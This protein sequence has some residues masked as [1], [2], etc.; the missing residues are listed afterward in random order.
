ME[1]CPTAWKGQFQGREK[2]AGL[3]LEAVVDTNLWFWHAAFGFS[4]TL[5]DI[6]IWERSALLES[7]VNGEYE[8]IDFNY[9]VDGEVFSIL[10][11]LV[12]G[13][14]PS[15]S[16]FILSESDPHT[17]IAYSFATDQESL[18]K[19]VERGFGVLKI[20]FLAIDSPYQSTSLS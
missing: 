5:N 17:N 18:R 9:F 13:V 19:D 20:N 3:G 2:Y 10:F 15:L 7:M 1:N 12:D 8:K 16:Y 11:Y 4:G 6:N 14:Y